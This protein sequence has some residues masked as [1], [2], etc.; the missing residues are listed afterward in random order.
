MKKNQITG[1]LGVLA[2][3]FLLASNSFSQVPQ[4]MSYQ[5]IVR[6]AT[7]ELV[8]A[9]KINMRVSIVQGSAT[10][11]VVYVETD[12]TTTNNNGLATI[13]LGAGKVVSG[14][15]STINWANGPYYIKTETDLAGGTNFTLTGV[16]QFLSVPYAFHAKTVEIDNVTDAD[17]DPANE[18]QT[19]SLNG[20]T[21][22]LSKNGG[23][24]TLP[25]SGTG[26]DQW[27]TQ[28]VVTDPSLAGKGTVAEP[29]TLAQRSAANGQ[30]LKWDGTNWTPA[31]DETGGGGL[32]LPFSASAAYTTIPFTIENT[33]TSDVAIFASSNSR[34]GIGGKTKSTNGSCGVYGEGSGVGYSSGVAGITGE[35]FYNGVPGNVGVLGQSDANIAVAGDSRSGTAGYFK[36]N[37][38][39]ALHSNGAIQLQGIGEAAGYVLTSDA[40]GNATWQ[41]A[42]GGFALPL[43]QTFSHGDAVIAI[44]NSSG[45]GIR[46]IAESS[47]GINSGLIGISNSYTGIG[48]SG[49]ANSTVG[50]NYGILGQTNS[51]EGYGVYG[52]AP[53]Y[54]LYG[55]ATSQSINSYGVFG[56]GYIGVSGSSSDTRG[57]GVSGHGYI[58][59]V[60]EGNTGIHAV[61]L[62]NEATSI[63]LSA[64]G[65]L[66]GVSAAANRPEGYA[67]YFSGKMSVTG[68]LGLG[69]FEP[70]YKLDV[71]G[72]AN[73]NSGIAEPATALRCNGFEALW[74]NGT[75]FSWGFGA[76]SHN[77]FHLP[78]VVGGWASPEGH[79][80]V[81]SG[82]AA[83][84]DGS[85]WSNLSDAR[86]KNIS[87]SYAKGL[88]EISAL[89]PVTFTYKEGNARK[90]DSTK[91]QIGFVAQEVQEV[92]PE[93]V[94]TGED[95]Y[96]EFNMHAVNVALVNAIKELKN[97]NENLK[98]KNL[99]MEARLTKL[100]RMIEARTMK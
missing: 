34:I 79:M 7:G 15:F 48:V 17:A 96:L 64:S 19:L 29:L 8:K 28:Y 91:E 54:G 66:F 81:V 21:L 42:S 45:H 88:K 44:T 90:L 98:S 4:K 2:L 94:T 10:G 47:F 72:T 32:T 82:S 31:N 61:G 30:V 69:I 18:I 84:T 83:K 1:L 77:Y 56:T 6:N 99:E 95:G 97:E 74:F 87:G 25:T 40:N 5:A 50:R 11:T 16:N 78:V 73:L 86:L 24:V 39:K 93:A 71:A 26:G 67:G 49:L 14:I 68:N 41:Q 63:G 3:I 70:A 33:G 58:G 100:E 85:T 51:F 62:P 13:Q 60:G 27:G 76:T 59:I 35:P 75:Y 12:T 37:T 89:Q 80:L 9:K 20:N 46:G 92:F 23:N 57:I 22:S 55:E 36:S 43:S 52:T 38:G 65:N 53:N